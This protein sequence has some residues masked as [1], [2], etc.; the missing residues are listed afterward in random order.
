M[1]IRKAFPRKKGKLLTQS[2]H[3]GFLDILALPTLYIASYP[4]LGMRLTDSVIVCQHNAPIN[5]LP[6]VPPHRDLT[7]TKS[8][9][10]PLERILESNAPITGLHISLLL[11]VNIDQIPL[12]RSMFIGQTRSNP[13]LLP[14]RF[15]GQGEVGVG[16]ATY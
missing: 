7:Y 15:L 9:A 4:G 11:S 1:G 8:I 16:R 6:Q 3:C 14:G 10:S 2:V 12:I 5:I 13:H